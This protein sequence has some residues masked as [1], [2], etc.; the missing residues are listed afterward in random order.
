MHSEHSWDCTTPIDELLDAALAAGLGALALT[1]HN[2]IA[3]GLE[4]R[5][6]AVER[7]LPLH[8]VVGA[9]VK[10]AADGEI[11]GL[12]LHEGVRSGITS[13]GS[14]PCIRAQGG[15]VYVPPSF[16]HFHSTPGH[17]L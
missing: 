12:F 6:R 9:E 17:A 15:V 8:V 1:D 11:I 2:T 7:G 5:A 13:R 16:D 10:T 4:A 14:T 3:G